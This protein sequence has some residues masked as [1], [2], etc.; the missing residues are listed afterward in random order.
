MKALFLDRDGTIIEDTH[1]LHKP[2]E[3]R[4]IPGVAEALTI[5]LKKKYSLFLFTNQSGIGRGYYTLADAIACNNEMIEQLNLGPDIF[6]EICIA[7][8]TPE[9]PQK[10]RK[11]SPKF[12]LEMLEQYSLEADKCWMVGDRLSDLEAGINGKLQAAFVSTGKPMDEPTH[13]YIA[14]H[15]ILCFDNLLSFS[16][17]L[18][19]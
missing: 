11:P 6:K 1:Y 9:Q 2:E 13:Q 10:Y 4:L 17:H 18:P 19:E 5:A 16:R 3:V 15:S 14:D 8:E 12:I 7:Q